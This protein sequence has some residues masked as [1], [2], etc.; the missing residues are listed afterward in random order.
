MIPL[1][2]ESS[3]ASLREGKGCEQTKALPLSPASRCCLAGNLLPPAWCQS[4]RARPA[5][6]EAALALAL[7]LTGRGILYLAR[8]H[9]Y[10]MLSELVGVAR[11]LGSG[12]VLNMACVGPKG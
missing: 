4:F 8:C 11:P 12:H 3:G 5:T 10:D 7:R 1:Q 6:F 9:V 2:G